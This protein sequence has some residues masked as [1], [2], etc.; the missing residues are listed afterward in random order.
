MSILEGDG[1]QIIYPPT[2]ALGRP[3]ALRRYSARHIIKH[4][5]DVGHS[6]HTRAATT[7]WVLVAYCEEKNI[8]FRIERYARGYAIF[9]LPIIKEVYESNKA[10]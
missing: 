10:N 5:N 3:S 8:N 2:T 1:R 4:F 7:L 9:K 6:F